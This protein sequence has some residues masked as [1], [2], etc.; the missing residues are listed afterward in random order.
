MQ[1]DVALFYEI[2]GLTSFALADKPHFYSESTLDW[3]GS[4]KN[5][6][7]PPIGLNQAYQHISSRKQFSNEI[8]AFLLPNIYLRDHNTIFVH[9][10]AGVS[11]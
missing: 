10:G 4:N 5:Q 2:A 9:L 6:N 11:S 3:T 8:N 1:K 7:L